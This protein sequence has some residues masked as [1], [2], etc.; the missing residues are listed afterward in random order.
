MHRLMV[1]NGRMRQ[2]AH[3]HGDIASYRHGPDAVARV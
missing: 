2:P 3:P 1:D